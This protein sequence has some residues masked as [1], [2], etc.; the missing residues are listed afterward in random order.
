MT[1]QRRRLIAEGLAAGLIGYALIAAFFVALNLAAGRSALYTVALVGEALFTGVRE[2]TAVTLAAG[3]MLAFNGL[4]LAAC[5]L[6]GLFGAWL[7][8]EADRHPEFWYLALFLFLGA[9]VVSYAGVLALIVMVGSPLSTGSIVAASLVAAVGSGTYLVA[10]HRSVV[11][12]VRRARE[13]RAG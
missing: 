13:T 4:H 11:R 1:A 3:P 2:P 7:G 9:T 8:H 5:L 12:A 10:R 6:F